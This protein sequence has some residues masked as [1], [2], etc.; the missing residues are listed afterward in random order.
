VPPRR[1]HMRNAAIHD[2]RFCRTPDVREVR[3]EGGQ[4]LDISDMR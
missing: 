2:A 3:E 4:V 1:M